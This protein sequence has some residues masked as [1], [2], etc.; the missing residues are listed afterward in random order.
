M[1]SCRAVALGRARSES[2]VKTDFLRPRPPEPGVLIHSD[3]LRGLPE[4]PSG[5][6]E[7][8]HNY[9]K[10]NQPRAG[11]KRRRGGWGAPS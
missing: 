8:R 4:P 9:I 2:I 11:S 1:E 5:A 6:G 3:S 7:R 10:Y